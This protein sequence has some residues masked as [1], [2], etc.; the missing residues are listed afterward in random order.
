MVWALGALQ[1]GELV[2]ERLWDGIDARLLM[3]EE[4]LNFSSAPF[5]FF[6]AARLQ[7]APS[8]E[9]DWLPGGAWCLSCF[10]LVLRVGRGVVWQEAGGC[11]GL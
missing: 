5:Y 4:Q 7:M 9:C 1:L 10:V 8:G 3:Q 2:T 6:G 11:S